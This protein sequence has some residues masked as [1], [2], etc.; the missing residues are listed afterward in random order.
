M[1]FGGSRLENKYIRGTCLLLS[2][3]IS[4]LNCSSYHVSIRVDNVLSVCA[5]LISLFNR[6][7]FFNHFI[8]LLTSYY[9]IFLL[10][11]FV[12]VPQVNSID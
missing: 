3:N 12:H 2:N 1:V 6:F 4:I 7:I 11:A 5:F 10:S 9:I 8:H